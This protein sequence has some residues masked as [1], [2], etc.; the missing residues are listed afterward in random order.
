MDA[1]S[2]KTAIVVG[3]A[4][5]GVIA[6][7]LVYFGNPGNMGFC[8]ACF[9]RDTAGALGLDSAA[10]VQYIRPEI[11]GLILGSTV[12][13][14]ANKEF[15]PKG[16]SAPVTRFV[17]GIACGVVFLN[18]GYSLARSHKMGVVE[19]SVMPVIAVVLLV[20]AIAAPEFIHFTE[21]GKGPGA[22]HAALGISLV[23]GLVVGAIAQRTRLC[24]VGGIRD[25]ILFRDNKLIL[26]FVAIFAAALATNLVL[27]AAT[28]GTFF[29][30]G[31]AEQPIAHTDALWNAL[32]TFLLGLS[33]ALLGGCPLRQTVLSGEGNSDSTITIL[34]LVA[35]AAFCHN[36]GLASS[37]SGPT[38]NGM[39][40]T[41]LG[42]VVVLAIAYANSLS[43]SE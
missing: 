20:L 6:S 15:A 26:G 3:G 19:G 22:L 23:A 1:K 16:G 31:F 39:V 17:L 25:L 37:G 32:G 38:F 7:L 18:R 10:A 29:K 27:T 9:M 33:C 43:R 4:V 13:A 21:A 41:V 8:I 14:V 35:G 30:L 11:I 28:P 2:E 34:G 42:I 24:M 40:A 12:M 5:I 36:F